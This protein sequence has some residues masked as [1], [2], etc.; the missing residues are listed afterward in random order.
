MSTVLPRVYCGKAGCTVSWPR[1]PILEV[2]CPD[3]KART[4]AHCKR[5]SGH[6][7]W[8]SSHNARDI[9]ADRMGA[10]GQC[11]S[12]RCGLENAK[13]QQQ[14]QEVLAL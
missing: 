4:G 2:P 14:K 10:Y 11:P 8:G 5:P 3:C 13:Q 6:R 1:D 7:A 12:G 9:L